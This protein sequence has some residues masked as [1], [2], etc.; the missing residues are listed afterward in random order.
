MGNILLGTQRTNPIQGHFSDADICKQAITYIKI[1][2]KIKNKTN[3]N[4]KKTLR[5]Q[6]NMLQM[7]EQEKSPEE[8][9]NDVEIASL[10]EKKFRVMIVKMTQELGKTMQEESKK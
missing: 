4:K 10:P 1:Q 6:R 8:Q 5:W 7:K 9:L 2:T 3:Q